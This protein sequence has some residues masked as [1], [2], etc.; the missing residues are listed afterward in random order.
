MRLL[1][2]ILH[3]VVIILSILVVAALLFAYHP[4]SLKFVA[5]QLQEN[6]IIAFTRV[7][8]SL[9]SGVTFYDLSYD[10]DA[11]SAAYLDVDYNILSLLSG[12]LQMNRVVIKNA[13][14][15]LLAFQDDA[16]ASNEAFSLPFGIHVK[17]AHIQDLQLIDTLRYGIS[18]LADDVRITP[19]ITISAKTLRD[20]RFDLNTSTPLHVDIGG[21][22]IRFDNALH[23][24]AL[25]ADG[26]IDHNA[27]HVSG[28]IAKNRF[29][30]RGNIRYNPSYVET[31]TPHVSLPPSLN[32]NKISADM[33]QVSI[34]TM[35]PDLF[36]RNDA[37]LSLQHIAATAEYRYVDSNVTLK[38]HHLLETSDIGID[39]L[40]NINIGFDA[41][42]AD[43]LHATLQHPTRPLPLKDFD[44]DV[45]YKEGAF[46]AMVRSQGH[47][48]DLN[49]SD[50]NRIHFDLGIDDLNLSE[51]AT[52]PE[53]LSSSRLD[54]TAKGYYDINSSL[55]MGTLYANAKHSSFDGNVSY[56]QEHLVTM[57][58]ISTDGNSRFWQSLPLRN[59]GG[60]D[61]VADI[62]PTHKML[63][64]NS[65]E[66]HTTLFQKEH[67][68]EG[69]GALATTAFDLSGSVDDGNTTLQLHSSIGS[70]YTLAESL[71]DLNLSENQ[72]FDM[73]VELNSTIAIDEGIRI[74]VDMLLPWYLAKVDAESYHYGTNAQLGLRYSN[75]AYTLEHYDVDYE[76]YK[77]FAHR[78]SLIT[79]DNDALRLH[80]LWLN[81]EIA[82]KGA[83]TFKE[84]TLLLNADSDAFHYKGDEGEIEAALHVRLNY[85]ANVTQIDGDIE[86]KKALITYEA[87]SDKVVKD[88]DI[89]VIQDVKAPLSSPLEISVRV[90]AT[91]PLHYKIKS[92]DLTFVPDITIW[93]ER[94]HN[95]ELLGWIYADKG[96]IYNGS[97]EFALQHSEI[98][99]SG[100]STIDPL[101]NLHLLYTI[102]N[103]FIDIYA[104][105]TLH[106]PVFLFTSSP[107]MSQS[108]IMSYIL[109]GTPASSSFESNEGGST[110]INAANIVFGTGL[111]EMIGDTTG[112]RVDTLNL[113]S[114]ADGGVGF[115]VGTRINRDLRVVLKNDDI[116]TLVLQLSLNSNLRVDVDVKETG[117]GVNLIY[118]QEFKDWLQ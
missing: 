87:P 32:L 58:H 8:G 36:L 50:L 93:K 62:A 104:T 59:I 73:G 86:I 88:D 11:L 114:K 74:D 81:D 67:K 38:L 69:W 76:G 84:K 47:H 33:S 40:H 46:G 12:T 97:S 60:V 2:H 23:V 80:P 35:V 34:S 41:A 29:E 5:Q 82:I 27:L 90:H 39:I 83:Y 13:R 94:E 95:L 4:R 57:G 72:V 115:E 7:E 30:G 43:T 55:L 68:I 51:F 37:N 85:D 28:T 64:I 96:W 106:S 44:A 108:D 26:T 98:Y 53:I 107:A 71:V 116:F 31:L 16:N 89:I 79:Y 1:I 112:L 18:V 91:Q 117:Q 52:L 9:A 118:V 21:S 78:P 77:L 103:K 6:D 113:I 65:E 101:L 20:G 109:F 14:V 42:V 54:A 66:F 45:L 15:M 25:K 22:N 10:H 17:S 92:V 111:K 99:F 56:I 70:L 110:S 75:G 100:G 49:S 63:Y 24:K 3:Y 48:L 61:L 102:D 19:N 105:H